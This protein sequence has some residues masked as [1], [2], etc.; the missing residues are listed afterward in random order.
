[1][2][3]TDEQGT[4]REGLITEAMIAR[5]AF[6]IS[7]TCDSAS[8]EDNWSQAEQE[9]YSELERDRRPG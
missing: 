4:A 2:A 7:L 8:P 5:R 6:E 9:L 3:R 1:M